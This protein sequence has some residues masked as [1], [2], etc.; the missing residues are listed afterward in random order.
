MNDLITLLI[1]FGLLMLLIVTVSFTL[2]W[3]GGQND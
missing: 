3:V 1:D 2:I